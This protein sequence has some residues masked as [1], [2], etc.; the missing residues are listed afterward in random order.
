MKEKDASS[1]YYCWSDQFLIMGCD[2]VMTSH[3]CERNVKKQKEE[4]IQFGLIFPAS[5]PQ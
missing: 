5:A 1:S 2:N 3:K 4:G